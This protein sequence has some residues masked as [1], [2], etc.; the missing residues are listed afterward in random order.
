[1]LFQVFAVAKILVANKVFVANKLIDIK[2]GKKLI[3]K[4]IK[5][6]TKKLYKS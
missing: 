4:F 5:L 1:M 6:K 3:K 2:N